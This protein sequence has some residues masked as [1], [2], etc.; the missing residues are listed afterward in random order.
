MALGQTLTDADG[1]R[2]PM[3]GILD[4]ET[5]FQAR[6]LHLGYRHLRTDHTPLA[7]DWAGHEFHYSTTVTETGAPLFTATDA[8][9]TALPPMGLRRGRVAGSF[10]HLIERV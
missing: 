9:G 8:E 7:G 5:S 10:A 2:F 4:L 6:K 1:A 3:A